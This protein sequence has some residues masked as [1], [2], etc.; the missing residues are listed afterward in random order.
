[1]ELF[2]LM[3]SVRKQSLYSCCQKSPLCLLAARVSM[4]SLQSASM[5]GRELLRV[6]GD[7]RIRKWDRNLA[8]TLTRSLPLHKE[9][10]FLTVLEG[11]HF[12]T[13]IYSDKY[14]I[15]HTYFNAKDIKDERTLTYSQVSK[16]I[17]PKT[18]RLFGIFCCC[19]VILN[20]N[21]LAQQN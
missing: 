21:L 11:Q 8:E 6:Q 1:M 5:R 10:C 4:N 13:G 15:E 19:P 17:L 2:Y 7:C 12:A 14:Q 20:L 9:H 3:E 16:N 18:C